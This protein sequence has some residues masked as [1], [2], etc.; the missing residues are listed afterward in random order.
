MARREKEGRERGE[1]RKGEGVGRKGEG[2][3][4]EKEGG[5]KGKGEG[6]K[7]EGREGEGETEGGR[8]PANKKRFCNVSVLLYDGLVKP[9]VVKTL[10]KRFTSVHQWYCWNQR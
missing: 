4:G 7:G 9:N 8:N 3:K 1:G 5:R 2:R 10:F 6:R